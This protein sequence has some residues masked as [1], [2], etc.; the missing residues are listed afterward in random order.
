MRT[1]VIGG[2]PAGM[3]AAYVSKQNNSHVLLLEKNARLGKKLLMTGHGRCNVTN[4][5]DIQAFM[6]HINTN[7]KFMYSPLHQFSSQDMLDFLEKNKIDTKEEDNHR[8]FP[9]SDSAYTILELF[10]SLLKGVIVRTNEEVLSLIIEEDVCKGVRTNKKTYYADCIIVCTGGKSYPLTG[11]NGS[12]YNLV[13]DYHTIK[14]PK[15]ALSSLVIQ[16]EWLKKCMGTV[17]KNVEIRIKKKRFTGDVLLTHFGISGPVVL[18]MSSLFDFKNTPIEVDLFP[19]M[20]EE[21]LNQK[22]LDLFSKNSN[23]QIQTV[24]NT[25]LPSR[26]VEELLVHLKIEANTLVHQMK[27]DQRRKILHILKHLTIT[28]LETRGFKD[29]MVTKGGISVK[30][31]NPNAMESKK[32]KNLKFAGEVIDVDAQTGGYNLQIAWSTGYVAGKNQI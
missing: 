18:N 11:S 6:S 3:M 7:A 32:I 15:P 12:G 5:C 27:K 10:E 30:E 14:E 17:L 4:N 9:T 8:M 22:I 13:K 19:K 2:G 25:L 28:I 26:F 16:E 20:S 24:L 1:I 23:K 31:I 21:E 29:A